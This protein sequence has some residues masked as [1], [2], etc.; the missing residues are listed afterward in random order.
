MSNIL[1]TNK[2]GKAQIYEPSSNNHWVKF[3]VTELGCEIAE[4]TVTEDG[5]IKKEIIAHYAQY[6]H[7]EYLRKDKAQAPKQ[8]VKTVEAP[9]D[10]FTEKALQKRKDIGEA[11]YMSLKPNAANVVIGNPGSES[12]VQ[13]RHENLSEL[14][15]KDPEA[16][17][18]ALQPAKPKRICKQCGD[19]ITGKHANAKFCGQKCKDKW[20]NS[21]HKQPN[22]ETDEQQNPAS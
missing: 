18:N 14:A 20:H 12:W 21:F 22:G 17:Y 9:T 8:P 4:Y 16:A 2:V 7:V 10:P 15:K 6:G 11:D 3:I 13:Q 1:I 19:D 5:D